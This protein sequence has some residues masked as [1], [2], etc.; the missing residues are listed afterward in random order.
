VTIVAFMR[1][2]AQSGIARWLATQSSEAERVHPMPPSAATTK[3]TNGPDF[4]W[5]P[6]PSMRFPAALFLSCYNRSA[7][8][9]TF[10]Y[11]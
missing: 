3:K 2:L 9:L 5:P 6:Y 7:T 11:L 4:A 1:P 10:S 8:G